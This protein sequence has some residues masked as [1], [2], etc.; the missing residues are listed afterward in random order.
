MPIRMLNYLTQLAYRDV[1]RHGLKNLPKLHGVVIYVG[2]KAG[3][4]DKGIY[5]FLNIHGQPSLQKLFRA[6]LQAENMATFLE[7]LNKTLPSKNGNE[8]E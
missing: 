8:E 6:T 7:A 5:N 4:N 2:D 3:T 1:I